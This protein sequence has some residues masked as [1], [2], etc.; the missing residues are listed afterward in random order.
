MYLLDANVFI[1]AKNRYYSFDI[2]PGFWKWMDIQTLI[3]DVA[4]I[5]TVCKELT[6]GNDALA[7]WI[8]NRKDDGLF[9]DISDEATQGAF[10]RIASTVQNGTCTTAAKADFLSK[11]DPWLIAKALAIG[12]TI[13]TH[14]QPT[15]EARK[16]VLIPNVCADF[17]IPYMNTF[18]LL[19][20]LS[21]SFVL[22]GSS[23]GSKKTRAKKH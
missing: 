23:P 13:V 2:C 17:N 8:N 11:A 1:E 14:E 21:V 15:P 19:H 4:S 3:G 10:K 12:A 7:E 22:Q 20:K 9:L 16:R 6:D 18:D 5:V